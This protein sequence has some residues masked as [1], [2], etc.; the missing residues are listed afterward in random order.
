MKKLIILLIIHNVIYSEIHS[1]NTELKVVRK[2]NGTE[3]FYFKVPLSGLTNRIEFEELQEKINCHD[4]DGKKIQLQP[5]DIKEISFYYDNHT[6]RMLSVPTMSA[7]SFDKGYLNFKENKAQIFLHLIDD[8]KLQVFKYYKETPITQPGAIYMGK[9]YAKGGVFTS[10]NIEEKYLLRRGSEIFKEVLEDRYFSEDM[11]YYFSDCPVLSKMI[12][13]KEFRRGHLLRIVK[14]Y[15]SN[16]VG[17][18]M[19]TD[20][21]KLKFEEMK[22]SLEIQ[23]VSESNLVVKYKDIDEVEIGDFVRYRDYNNN[24]S[25]GVVLDKVDKKKIRVKILIPE[26]KFM[27]LKF[28]SVSKIIQEIKT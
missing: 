6:Y 23:K 7:E 14:Y 27:N 5:N 9:G 15:N 28:K 3:Y 12:A 2:N 1:Q 24:I 21:E 10:A 11:S 25:F 18:I 17:N 4:S 8:G 19:L 13:N 20:D 26:I 16:C 22:T